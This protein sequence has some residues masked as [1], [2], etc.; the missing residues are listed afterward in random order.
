MEVE[1]DGKTNGKDEDDLAKYNLADYDKESKSIGALVTYLAFGVLIRVYCS[2]R[3][4][5]G[6]ES[7]DI[8]QKQR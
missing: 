1:G 2:F 4:I 3:A 8:L 7:S 5:S 6:Y